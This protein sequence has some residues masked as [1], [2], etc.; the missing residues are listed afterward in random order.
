MT[1]TSPDCTTQIDPLDEAVPSVS[2]LRAEIAE[3]RALLADCASLV[4]DAELPAQAK[5]GA[6]LAAARLAGAS[7]SA[8]SAIARIVDADS[9]QMLAVDRVNGGSRVRH[10]RRAPSPQPV[11]YPEWYIHPGSEKSENE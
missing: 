11:D 2:Q 4:R 10:V 6:A 3:C 7:A 1:T 9:R 5:V 8:A